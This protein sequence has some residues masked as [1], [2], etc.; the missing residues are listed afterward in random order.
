MIRTNIPR[1]INHHEKNI[2]K[3]DEIIDVFEFA[4][5]NLVI[6]YNEKSSSKTILAIDYAEHFIEENINKNICVR[7][8]NSEFK[9]FLH[10]SVRNELANDLNVEC[11]T[12]KVTT[13]WTEI[14]NKLNKDMVYLFIFDNVK[15]W[16]D[17]Q[18][19]YAV[20]VELIDKNVK[21]I[22]TTSDSLIQKIENSYLKVSLVNVDDCIVDDKELEK[23]VIE[24]ND[25]D[26]ELIDYLQAFKQEFVDYELL[27]KLFFKNKDHSIETLENSIRNLNKKGLIDEVNFEGKRLLKLNYMQQIESYFESIPYHKQ[28][29][30][31]IQLKFISIN[32]DIPDDSDWLDLKYKYFTFFCLAETL[33]KNKIE[34]S[35]VF[36]TLGK[37]SNSVSDTRN[38][39]EYYNKCFKIR[40]TSCKKLDKRV[41]EI[42]NAIAHYYHYHAKNVTEF[43]EKVSIYLFDAILIE[44][45]NYLINNQ[46]TEKDIKDIHELCND[47]GATF[48]KRLN[49]NCVKNRELD[50][51]QSLFYLFNSLLFYKKFCEYDAYQE[52]ILLNNI[53]ELLKK[54]DDKNEMLF[55][56]N[57]KAV[58]IAK[59]NNIENRD[60]ANLWTNKSSSG[61]DIA[62]QLDMRLI[63]L[64][65]TVI[66]KLCDYV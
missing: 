58:Q 20:F 50:Q 13:L 22:V 17:I 37:I 9:E 3:I 1:L 15:K 54:I 64:F 51:K 6:L 24:L 12:T 35:D 59:Y 14:R 19:I 36:F 23:R 49:F 21:I 18:D 34:L 56:I 5:T 7:W 48:A 38:E 61:E 26:I 44:L 11:L 41:S 63:S 43:E 42:K 32:L 60:T 2:T 30:E 31:E 46:N 33:N 55:G 25:Q 65:D 28:K 39:I 47:L 16:T 66:N 10:Q 57:E 4:N 62:E 52:I 45:Y 53:S 40:N 29:I 27:S 8:Y